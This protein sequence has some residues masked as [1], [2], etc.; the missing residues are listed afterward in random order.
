MASLS[1]SKNHVSNKQII[2]PTKKDVELLISSN[3]NEL[4]EVKN[5]IENKKRDINFQ[6]KDGRTA[7]IYASCNG[8]LDIVK[9]LCE[10]GANLNLVDKEYNN[11]ALMFAIGHNNEEVAKYLIE[12]GAD[13]TVKNTNGDTPLH[14]AC[15]KGNLNLVKLLHEKGCDLNEFNKEHNNP[16]I[17]SVGNNCIDIVEYLINNNVNLNVIDGEKI[18]LLHMCIGVNLDFIE[19]KNNILR[20][21]KLKIMKMILDKDTSMID[22]WCPKDYYTP[23]LSA[24]MLNRVEFIKMLLEYGANPNINAPLNYSPLYHAIT[25]CNY[26]P[27]NFEII[28]LLIEKGADVNCRSHVLSLVSIHGGKYPLGNSILAVAKGYFNYD[29]LDLLESKNAIYARDY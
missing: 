20:N 22:Y 10:N 19:D 1:Y 24:T 26:E 21:R 4:E 29:V 8:T 15:I 12:K 5:Q 13:I 2:K 18:S 14:F 28:K 25:C 16:I 17:F 7:L 23:L 3:K 9:Y 6:L 11:S 27:N